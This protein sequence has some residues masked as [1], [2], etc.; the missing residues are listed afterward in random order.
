MVGSA[1]YNRVWM[2][3]MPCVTTSCVDHPKLDSIGQL[4]VLGHLYLTKA[5]VLCHMS[6]RTRKPHRKR[7]MGMYRPYG[8]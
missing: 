5:P 3:V 7:V 1:Q 8:G 6:H 4:V 2:V